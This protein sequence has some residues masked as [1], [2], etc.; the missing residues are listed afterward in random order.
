MAENTVPDPGFLHR[1]VVSILA[2]LAKIRISLMALD[3]RSA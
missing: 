3:P 2:P 1:I